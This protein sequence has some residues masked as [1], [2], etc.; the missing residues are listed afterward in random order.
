[1]LAAT[2]AGAG[3]AAAIASCGGGHRNPVVT[4]TISPEQARSDAAIM[5]SLL[6]LERTAII[7]YTT[8]IPRLQGPARAVAERFLAHE[9]AH[10]HAIEQAIRGLDAHPLPARPN[11][12][13]TQGFP[14][15]DSAEAV[16]RFALD[17][18]NTQISAYGESVG[19]V[20]TPELR[21]TLTSI[22]A[23]EAEH[24]SDLLGELQEPQASQAHDTGNA[25]A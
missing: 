24:I 16:L 14:P 2:G 7:A 21:A 23:V 8:G 25:P 19:A 18:E 1:M 4:Q 13:Y 22:L 5:N 10:Q 15:L 6:D 17:I 9:R 20:V 3:V 12:D 11:R